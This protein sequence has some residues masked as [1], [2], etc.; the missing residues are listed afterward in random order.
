MSE[1]ID[2]CLHGYL[3]QFE[4]RSPKVKNSTADGKIAFANG[5]YEEACRRQARRVSIAP[6][7]CRA[8]AQQRK[9]SSARAA[10]MTPRS[11]TKRQAYDVRPQACASIFQTPSR[12]ANVYAR[13]P[14]RTIGWSL[15][16]TVRV[17]EMTAYADEPSTFQKPIS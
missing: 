12:L 3:H 11:E 16:V 13:V 4:Q 6:E 9:N 17:P 10:F 14:V 8:D 1:D 2:G 5:K 7:S 15:I